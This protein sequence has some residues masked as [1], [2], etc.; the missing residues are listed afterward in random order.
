LYLDSSQELKDNNGYTTRLKYIGNSPNVEL[1]GRLH[2]D[3]FKSYK[4]LI[5][6]VNMSIKLT[7]TP[8]AFY[9]L[10]PNGDTKVLSNFWTLLSLSLKSN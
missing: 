6:G 10:A 8:E 3:F 2:A 5:N 9:L 7:R 4:M 1:Y